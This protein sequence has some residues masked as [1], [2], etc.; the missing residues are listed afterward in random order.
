MKN[1]RKCYVNTPF[2]NI[3]GLQ[4]AKICDNIINSASSDVSRKLR[5]ELDK[6]IGHMHTDTLNQEHQNL[7]QINKGYENMY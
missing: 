7:K 6:V 2:L 3:T 5:N 4:K 1:I